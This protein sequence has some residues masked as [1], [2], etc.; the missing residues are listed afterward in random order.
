MP[1]ISLY[2][3]V[4]QPFRLRTYRFFEIGEYSNYYEDVENTYQMQKIAKNCYLPA[5]Q[6]LLG[7]IKKYGKDFKV[8]FSIS[9]TALEQFEAYAPEVLASFK[10]LA[11]T[12][13]VEFLAE[14]YS[15]SLIALGSQEDFKSDVEKHADKIEALFGQRPEVF[16]NTE[17]IYNNEIGKSVYEMGFKAMITEGAKH[18]MGWKSSNNLYYNALAPE[19][20][21]I[22]R[23]FK[24]SDDIAFRFSNYDW[25]QYP[26]T[27]D[28]FVDWLNNTEEGAEVINLFM[29]Y[30]TFGEHQ[31][32]EEGILNFLNNLGEKVVKSG[33]LKFI[34]PSEA[35]K[36]L[37][38]VASLNVEHTISWADE[39]RDTT[40]WLGND[41]QEDAFET[42]GKIAEQ[43]RLVSRPELKRDWARLQTSDHFYYMSTKQN[44]D[45]TVHEYF[46]PYKSPYDAFINYMNVLSDFSIR[47]EKEYKK[48]QSN[49]KE[50]IKKEIAAYKKQIA[51]LEKKLAKPLPIEKQKPK[52]KAIAKT[53]PKVKAIVKTKKVAKPIAKTKKTPKAAISKTK[54]Q[55]KAIPPVKKSTKNKK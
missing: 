48:V 43:M 11:D 27:A 5:N 46:T 30:E 41:M 49:N 12:G 9:G 40:A 25:D 7:L 45:G 47:V 24:L 37:Q 44:A 20:K 36:T 31:S 34:T 33:N 52:R 39:E 2:F 28:K 8:T 16:R 6:V 32:K 38:P 51:K 19:L 54:K 1:N 22:L 26:L 14:T 15:H 55:P 4:H 29:D 21:L 42:L 10:A 50:A 53:K 17:L 3:Q 18:I 23:N 13:S 35:A